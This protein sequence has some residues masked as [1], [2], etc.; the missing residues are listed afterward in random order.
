MSVNNTTSGGVV[1]PSQSVHIERHSNDASPSEVVNQRKIEIENSGVPS[2][3]MGR[4][5]LISGRYLDAQKIAKIMKKAGKKVGLIEGGLGI[6]K[7]YGTA[8]L[9]QSLFSGKG[10][11]VSHRIGLITQT[12]KTFDAAHYRSIKFEVGGKGV[13]RIGSTLHSLPSLMDIE[14]AAPAFDR[15]LLVVDESNSCAA[16]I[17]TSTIKNE[18]ETLN[19]LGA[20]YQSSEM[21]LCLDAHMDRSTV[22][23]LIAAGI[24]RDE[25]LLITIDYPEL[26]GYTVRVFQDEL[27]DSDKPATRAAFINQILS[28]LVRGLKVIVNSL[29][30][31]F[32]DDLERES[33][34]RNIS[35]IIKITSKTPDLVKN[36]LN[37]ESYQL[38]ELVMLSPTMN[39]GI[40]F[41]GDDDYRHADRCYVI[42]SNTSGTGSYQDA[43]QAMMR[44][45]AVND[46][47]I[48]VYYAESPIPLPTVSK[49]AL[50]WKRD[51]D[52]LI[53]ILQEHGFAEEWEKRR[54]HQDRVDDF[55]LA[56]NLKT[57]EE[58]LQFLPLFIRECRLKGAEVIMCGLS[59]LSDGDVTYESLKEAK[60][61]EEAKRIDG[62]SNAMKITDDMELPDDDSEETRYALARRYVEREAVIDL[63][64]L[65]PYEKSE[66][67]RMVLPADGGGV[68]PIVRSFERAL[69]DR[70]VLQ[71]VVKAALVGVAVD[72]R[73]RVA[74]IEKSTTD[75]IHWL[76][77]AHL[78]RLVLDFVGVAGVAG[79]LKV[80]NCTLTRESICKSKKGLVSS[81]RQTGVDV[82]VRCGLLPSGAD[83]KSDPVDVVIGL[84]KSSGVK[85]RKVRGKQAWKVD[86]EALSVPIEMINRRYGA[87]LKPLQDW[88]DRIEQY[89]AE[90]SN[91]V[92]LREDRSFATRIETRCGYTDLIIESLNNIGKP[93]LIEEALVYFEPFRARWDDGQATQSRVDCMVSKWEAT[94]SA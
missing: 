61:E 2:V 89:K 16:E 69:E 62:I 79:D 82:A 63:D 39:T 54:P 24:P 50:R 90:H 47:T 77:R 7:S 40:S 42:A 45:R 22:G 91:R 60:A 13:E 37:A 92:A 5:D 73:D 43:L 25:M 78:V 84:I 72:D 3:F 15:G 58:K 30:A 8:Q 10:V 4:G 57:A 19:A 21:M 23:M 6:G 94:R 20:A 36:G 80:D 65:E 1:T 49:I 9:M 38:Y 32:L 14:R 53:E 44:E 56:Q 75:K 74:F 33:K 51:T 55:I 29:S 59:E 48:N 87:G 52:A 26:E 71:E 31:K 66:W 67:V 88:L 85:L 86:V 76:D 46:K 93:D 28:D 34:K 68:L 27:D 41:D 35:N 18:A 83:F 70:K 17:I 11:A 12:C 81:L 64:L